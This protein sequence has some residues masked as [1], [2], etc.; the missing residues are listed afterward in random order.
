MVPMRVSALALLLTFFS[1]GCAMSV[2]ALYKLEAEVG[3]RNQA[4]Y[5]AA[6]ESLRARGYEIAPDVLRYATIDEQARQRCIHGG[7]PEDLVELRVT[8]STLPGATPAPALELSAPADEACAFFS[9]RHRELAA[10]RAD[11]STQLLLNLGSVSFVRDAHG[12]LAFLDVNIRVIS[13]R[14]VTVDMECNEMPRP[15]PDPLDQPHLPVVLDPAPTPR[16]SMDVEREEL[17]VECTDVVE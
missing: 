4:R 12:A 10:R 17:D 5:E 8:A 16:V 2:N 1:T 7:A 15:A 13:T 11:G 14:T 3:G 9:G 6:I